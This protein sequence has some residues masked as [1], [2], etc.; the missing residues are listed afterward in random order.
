MLRDDA[1]A[2]VGFVYFGSLRVGGSV[3]MSDQ[4]IISKCHNLLG[5]QP[6]QVYG[7]LIPKNKEINCLISSSTDLT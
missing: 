6:E 2:L 7:G 1:P 3:Q 4:G 5:R